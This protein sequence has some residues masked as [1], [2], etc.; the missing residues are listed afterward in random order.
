MCDATMLKTPDDS[1]RATS[2]TY[3]QLPCNMNPGR[4]RVPPDAPSVTVG[5][6]GPVQQRSMWQPDLGLADRQQ[7]S[8]G[9][10]ERASLP[11]T[12]RCILGV[13]VP[14]SALGR[15]ERN[16]ARDHLR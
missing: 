16:N 4:S 12:S 3:L 13:T 2:T 5:A 9:M 6:M 10:K 15:G 14:C 11:V 1:N 8:D 7:T